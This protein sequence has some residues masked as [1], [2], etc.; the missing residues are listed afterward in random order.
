MNARPASVCFERV[1]LQSVLFD[2]AESVVANKQ[3]FAKRASPQRRRRR[4]GVGRARAVVRTHNHSASRRPAFDRVA[5]RKSRRRSSSVTACAALQIALLGLVAAAS[6]GVKC[7]CACVARRRMSVEF[8]SHETQRRSRQAQNTRAQRHNIGAT[9][10]RVLCERFF[11]NSQR[12]SSLRQ[13]LQMNT[14]TFVPIA[15]SLTRNT[16]DRQQQTIINRSITIFL[17]LN[18]T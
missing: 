16:I 13:M 1:L 18:Q 15:T 3:H 4:R 5:R 7:S 8:R 11:G 14:Q 12:K 9:Q 2:V 17:C 6:R 10:A